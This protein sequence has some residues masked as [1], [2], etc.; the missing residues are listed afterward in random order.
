MQWRMQGM[1]DIVDIREMKKGRKLRWARNLLNK[2]WQECLLYEDAVDRGNHHGAEC[3]LYQDVFGVVLD[4]N[5]R[6]EDLSQETAN[7]SSLL[8]PSVE[9]TRRGYLTDEQSKI[10]RS[11]PHGTD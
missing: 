2:Q 10:D 8:L 4:D 11:S 7:H 1:V 3:L 6:R 9:M 5:G